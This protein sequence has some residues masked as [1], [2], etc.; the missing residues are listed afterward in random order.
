VGVC[1]QSLA[2]CWPAILRQTIASNHLPQLGMLH[3]TQVPVTLEK[4][5]LAKHLLCA[6]LPLQV[7]DTLH[8]FVGGPSFRHRSVDCKLLL[9]DGWSTFTS[10][11]AF[12]LK[13]RLPLT[14][15][16][17]PVHWSSTGVLLSCSEWTQEPG[18]S[19]AAAESFSAP[20]SRPTAGGSSGSAGCMCTQHVLSSGGG[21]GHGQR[22]VDSTEA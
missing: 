20:R 8:C 9:L 3:P 17:L 13:V 5:S 1:L 12:I 21:S 22:Y 16:C 19:A 14:P 15:M 11:H 6:L 2:T 4:Q 10:W 18:Y 7:T